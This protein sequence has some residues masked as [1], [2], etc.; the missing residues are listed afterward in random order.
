M[1]RGSYRVTILT[2]IHL[3]KITCYFYQDVF[4][5]RRFLSKAVILTML[6]TVNPGKH[7]LLSVGELLPHYV[8]RLLENWMEHLTEPAPVRQDYQDQNITTRR[9]MNSTFECD[10]FPFVTIMSNAEDLLHRVVLG[11]DITRILLFRGAEKYVHSHLDFTH[12]PVCVEIHHRNPCIVWTEAK[13][14]TE[15][16]NI[17]KR[18]LIIS[19]QTFV[20]QLLDNKYIC[21]NSV[22]EKY[23][24]W[25]TGL[26]VI[27]RIND[28]ALSTW[29]NASVVT[30]PT[31][32]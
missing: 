26:S 14:S 1:H 8:W 4:S 19:I 10:R 2:F 28:T 20:I 16:V 3:K 17:M 29:R 7:H 5:L 27:Y 30:L 11:N 22:K 25:Q 24:A 23:N 6:V 32:L 9:R 31:A 18:N 21:W 15:E 12:S 13:I